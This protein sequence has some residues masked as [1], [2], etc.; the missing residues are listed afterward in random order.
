M[1]LRFVR[2]GTHHLFGVL[3]RED[4]DMDFIERIFGVAPDAGSGAL[5]LLLFL[6]PIVGI[7]LLRWRAKRRPRKD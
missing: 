7:V 2:G 3:P 1:R 6:I 5:E 4:R